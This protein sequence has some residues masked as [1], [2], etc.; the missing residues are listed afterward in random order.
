[1]PDSFKEIALKS[2]KTKTLQEYSSDNSLD[3][4]IIK[5]TSKTELEKHTQELRDSLSK[6]ATETLNKILI[7]HYE[8]TNL[9]EQGVRIWGK[10]DNVVLA[11]NTV[12]E[13]LNGIRNLCPKVDFDKALFLA[14]KKS[15]YAFFDD[16]K[17]ILYINNNFFIPQ[18]IN[19]F[20]KIL[21]K[22]DSRSGWWEESVEI[23]DGKNS[24]GDGEGT[25]KVI[26]LSKSFLK[27]P[28]IDPDFGYFNTFFAGYFFSLYNCCS[29]FLRIIS[30][31]KFFKYKMSFCYDAFPQD[32]PHNGFTFIQLYETDKYFESDFQEIDYG[33]FVLSELF[34]SGD[35]QITSE[36]L[37][38]S[39]EKLINILNSLHLTTKKEQDN[40]KY[41]FTHNGL[42]R[43]YVKRHKMLQI[44]YDLKNT[45]DNFRVEKVKDLIK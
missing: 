40:L 14:G 7:P 18:D 28:W 45:Y 5:E 38:R 17:R 33:F 42:W 25:Y 26:R 9:R 8:F 20:L 1:M 29:D 15:G 31:S 22:F 21:F 32:E 10:K 19:D 23:T 24:Q 27:F 37:L 30:E 44:F 13:L 6:V 43:D 16:F 41:I 3:T 2:L 34:S 39:T 36:I 35:P 12:I 11:K 4:L